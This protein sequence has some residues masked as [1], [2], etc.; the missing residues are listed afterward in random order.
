MDLI[1]NSSGGEFSWLATNHT[2]EEDEE[3]EKSE[4]TLKEGPG[5]ASRTEIGGFM[6]GS[7]RVGR[8][9]TVIP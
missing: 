2:W 5:G 9:T 4:D 7:G 8:G 6:L 3:L 1:T